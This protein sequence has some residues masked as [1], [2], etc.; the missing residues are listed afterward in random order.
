MGFFRRLFTGSDAPASEEDDVPIQ[1]VWQR[2]A[3]LTL[4][5][6]TAFWDAQQGL[7]PTMETYLSVVARAYEL[8]LRDPE[9]LVPE[10]HLALAYAKG[11]SE[12]AERPRYRSVNFEHQDT[13]KDFINVLRNTGDLDR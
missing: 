12:L 1:D 6:L 2:V 10:R 4:P 13:F 5:E 8:A 3:K 7:D 11:L 9:T